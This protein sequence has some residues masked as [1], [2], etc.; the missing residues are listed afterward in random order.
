[1]MLIMMWGSEIGVRHWSRSR[2]WTVAFIVAV[3]LLCLL[4]LSIMGLVGASQG[5]RDARL[6]RM[7]MG[8]PVTGLVVCCVALL[9]SLINLVAC[10]L[11]AGDV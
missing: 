4:G 5:M 2:T 10:F 11:I 9:F 3:P 8:L 6:R 7:S 1:M